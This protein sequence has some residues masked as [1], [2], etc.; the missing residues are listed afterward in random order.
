MLRA[1]LRSLHS[2]DVHNLETYRPI[3][4]TRFGLLVQAMVGPE[5]MP[6]EESF[7]FIVCTP[8]WLAER[9]REQDYVTARHHIIFARY[10]YPVLRSVI[11]GYCEEAT[12]PDWR[13]V[14]ARLSRYGKWEFEDYRPAEHE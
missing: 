14:A 8:G 1:E 6:G 9:L 3:D 12:G 13:S 4:P 2:P 5:D 10:D 11:R 7:D